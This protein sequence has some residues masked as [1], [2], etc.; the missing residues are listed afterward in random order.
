MSECDTVEP[1][2]IFSFSYMQVT[3]AGNNVPFKLDLFDASL[4]DQACSEEQKKEKK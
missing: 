4:S 1:Q 2:V 3:M